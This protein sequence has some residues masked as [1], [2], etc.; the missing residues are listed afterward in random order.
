MNC[1]FRHLIPNCYLS[2]CLMYIQYNHIPTKQQKYTIIT[3]WFTT[4]L[5]CY[6]TFYICFAIHTASTFSTATTYQTIWLTLLERWTAFLNQWNKQLR[7]AILLCI[8][9]FM[10]LLI[11]RYC[12]IYSVF[13]QFDNVLLINEISNLRYCCYM[14]RRYVLHM[15]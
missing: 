2:Q 5:K 11:F 4:T 13:T 12:K 1:S 9:T 8:L 3:D 7:N 15:F 14:Q 6:C 10:M